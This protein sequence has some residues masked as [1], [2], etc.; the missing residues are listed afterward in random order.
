MSLLIVPRAGKFIADIVG[1]TVKDN[2]IEVVEMHTE[3]G[4]LDDVFRQLT[5]EAVEA[6]E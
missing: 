3:A 1:S 4:K 2:G 5:I 6:D